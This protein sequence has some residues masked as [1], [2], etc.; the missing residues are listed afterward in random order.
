MS[1]QIRIAANSLASDHVSAIPQVFLKKKTN[2]SF[3]ILAIKIGYNILATGI[4]A[5]LDEYIKKFDGQLKL[6]TTCRAPAYMYV[7]GPIISQND[8]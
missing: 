1:S 2:A 8:D 6:G 4:R 5:V 3:V 7:L